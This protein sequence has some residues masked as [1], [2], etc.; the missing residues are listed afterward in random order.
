MSNKLTIHQFLDEIDQYSCRV[1]LPEL[2]ERLQRLQLSPDDVREHLK[3]GVDCYQ[4]NLMRAGSA[5]AALILCW[6][7]GQRSPIHDHRGSS[8]GVYVIQGV[9]T[10]TVFDRT[11]HGH[12]YA[13]KSRTLAAGGVC[14]SQ[15]DDIH[16]V[17]NLQAP[18]EDLVTLHVYSPP[19]TQMG[20]YSLMDTRRGEF[21]GDEQVYKPLVIP[22]ETMRDLGMCEREALIEV[23]CRL[24]DAEKLSMPAAAKM[25]GKSR[26]EF[27]DELATR[28][29]PTIRITPEDLAQDV[30][31]LQRL[32]V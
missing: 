10:E 30:A 20:T 11:P 24:Y 8:C 15:D 9:V 1:P 29:L 5:Y 17:S 16:Q 7:S 23:A 28:G 18:G 6:R 26:M 27:F 14:G 19:L 12:I 21:P 4:R 22:A 31:T 13:T 25:C 2:V 32:G 3:F